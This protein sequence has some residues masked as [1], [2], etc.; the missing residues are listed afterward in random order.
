MGNERG[1]RP[2]K[3]SA[4]K[5]LH[6]DRADR[7]NDGEPVPGEGPI[8]PPYWLSDDALLVWDVLAE[9]LR[10][11]GVLTSWDVEAYAAFCAIV[12]RRR[13]AEA[14]LEREGEVIEVEVFRKDGEVSGTRA[15]RNPWWLVY[16]DADVLMS[17]YANRF[18]LTP[19]DRAALSV[20]RT[21]G[22]DPDDDLLS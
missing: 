3:P 2:R 18:G 10:R 21:G 15:M 11:T 12:V 1:G 20:R 9:D 13:R 17:R 5:A 19:S 22:R 4:L 8:E 7:R 16:R 14:A 6:G